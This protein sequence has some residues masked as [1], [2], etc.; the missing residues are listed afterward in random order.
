MVGSL[1]SIFPA[2]ANAPYRVTS[3][4]DTRYNCV[5]WAAGDNQTW[6]WPDPGGTAYWPA[7]APRSETLP[8][9]QKTFEEL[10]YTA[11]ADEHLERGFDKIAV[12]AFQ[13]LPTHVARQLDTGQ[14]TSKLGEREDI[15][16]DLHA[17][18]GAA[19]GAVVLFMKRQRA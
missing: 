13:G 6:W 8:A 18:E 11:A 12:F 9:F 5:A 4:A 15:E 17:L 14:W 1:E 7:Q 2:L 16:H 10:G 19:Y 3:A